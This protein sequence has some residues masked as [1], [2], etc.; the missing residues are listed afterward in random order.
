MRVQLYRKSI[1][2]PKGMGYL[3][4]KSSLMRF[5]QFANLKYKYVETGI[6]FAKD[7]MEV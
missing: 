7:M 5:D 1:A 4:G 2:Q 3:K 6:S